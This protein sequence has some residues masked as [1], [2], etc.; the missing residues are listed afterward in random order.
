MTQWSL[1]F[2]GKDD[3]LLDG[4]VAKARM[5]TDPLVC[6][7]LTNIFETENSSFELRLATGAVGRDSRQAC[8][9]CTNEAGREAMVH[10]ANINDWFEHYFRDHKGVGG[11]EIQHFNMKAAITHCLSMRSHILCLDYQIN[12]LMEE[13][14][15]FRPVIEKAINMNGTSLMNSSGK[16]GETFLPNAKTKSGAIVIALANSAKSSNAIAEL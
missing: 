3:V 9:R 2:A 5:L 6:P 15:H 10:F 11:P 7:N 8:I 14:H 13:F 4:T 16:S 12:E 1:A